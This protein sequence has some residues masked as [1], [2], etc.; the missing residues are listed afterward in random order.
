[1]TMA[2]VNSTLNVIITI[3]D[4]SVI[5]REQIDVIRRDCERILTLTN[6]TSINRESDV[7]TLIAMSRWLRNLTS[8]SRMMMIDLLTSTTITDTFQRYHA[9]LRRMFEIAGDTTY[10]GDDDM[11]H[12]ATRDKIEVRQIIELDIKNDSNP[13]ASDMMASLNSMGVGM[14]HDVPSVMENVRYARY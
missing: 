9:D 8:S 3:C 5:C 10:G 2:V 1:M 7:Q 14:D 13:I 6:T 11:V 4:T 12:A